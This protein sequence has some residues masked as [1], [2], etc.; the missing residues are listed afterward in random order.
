[1][2]EAYVLG[3]IV[4]H[5]QPEEQDDVSDD[6]EALFGGSSDGDATI[7]TMTDEQVALL[8]SFETT[9]R[10]QVTR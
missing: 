8:A 4:P 3:M 5:D 2:A 9:H 10:K 1:M 7:P 6:I